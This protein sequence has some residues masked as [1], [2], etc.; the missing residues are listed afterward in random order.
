[1]V[2]VR[3]EGS[4]GGV[5]RKCE[6]VKGRGGDAKADASHCEHNNISKV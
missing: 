3:G 2:E 1:M 4:D 5:T 6:G